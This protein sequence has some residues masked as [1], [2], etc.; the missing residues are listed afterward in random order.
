ML[1]A[2][3]LCALSSLARLSVNAFNREPIT[4]VT[5]YG[6]ER[7]EVERERG[8]VEETEGGI[9]KRIRR[10]GGKNEGGKGRKKKQ[11]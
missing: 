5:S 8:R 11:E 9:K 3:A 7:K 6:S 2:Q 1:G 10:N 4:A